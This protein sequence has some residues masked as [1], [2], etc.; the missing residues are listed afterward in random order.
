MLI[1]ICITLLLLLPMLPYPIYWRVINNDCDPLDSNAFYV[2][3][4][5]D[6]II[7]G[8]IP[9]MGMTISTIVIC[10]NMTQAAKNLSGQYGLKTVEKPWAN[11]E[12]TVGRPRR[13]TRTSITST[14]SGAFYSTKLR[15]N[16]LNSPFF[17]QKPQDPLQRRVP[18]PRTSIPSVAYNSFTGNLRRVSPGTVQDSIWSS[19]VELNKSGSTRPVDAHSVRHNAKDN[20]GQVTRLLVCMNIC[21]LASTFP[22]LTFLMFR[23]FS[24]VHVPP[25]I[26]RFAYY[27][28]RSFCFINS[29][30]NWIFYCLVGKRFRQQAKRIMLVCLKASRFRSEDTTE[31]QRIPPNYPPQGNTIEQEDKDGDTL[32]KQPSE[33]TKY[34]RNNSAVHDMKHIMTGIPNR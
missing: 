30:T 5:N 8:I 19:T 21:Y 25:D 17:I 6:L 16:T 2:T 20:T 23:N 31:V 24:S 27:L 13:L 33:E 22:L 34:Q 12:S 14:S 3:T 9:L 15:R 28:C 11:S 1:W 10:W 26:H 29:C 4:L 7:W 32:L 18:A